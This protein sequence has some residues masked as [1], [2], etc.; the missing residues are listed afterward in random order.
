MN[1]KK[2]LM[3]GDVVR[4]HSTV[5]VEKQLLSSHQWGA[6]LILQYIYPDCN[7]DLLLATLTHDAHEL[8]TGDIPAPLKWENKGVAEALSEVEV[9]WEKANGVHYELSFKE[10]WLM[11]LADTLEGLWFCAQQLKNGS[12]AS[13]YPYRKWEE[14]LDKHLMTHTMSLEVGLRIEQVVNIIRNE[15]TANDC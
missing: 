3:S 8:Y 12:R 15:A 11:K 9:T 4:F 13:I 10:E 1:I 5:G 2:V 6:S 14:A 7:K